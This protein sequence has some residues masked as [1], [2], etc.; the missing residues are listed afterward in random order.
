[1]SRWRSVRPYILTFLVVLSFGYLWFVLAQAESAAHPR[2]RDLQIDATNVRKMVFAP[3]GSYLVTIPSDGSK[4][5]FNDLPSGLRHRSLSLPSPT[6]NQTPETKEVLL[7]LPQRISDCAFSPNDRRLAITT[8]S[9]VAYVCHLP[10]GEN[11]F[12]VEPDVTTLVLPY[13]IDMK[14]TN[15]LYDMG[16]RNQSV[17]YSPDGKLL[18][19]GS[20]VRME[21][22]VGPDTE[23]ISNLCI[24]VYDAATLQYIRS[25]SAP[26]SRGDFEDM[27]ISPDGRYVAIC[28]GPQTLLWE[29][30]TGSLIHHYKEGG[31]RLRFSGDS[32][33]LILLD[34]KGQLTGLPIAA[35]RVEPYQISS[36]PLLQPDEWLDF[37]TIQG[38]IY[39][40]TR[41]FDNAYFR[42][43][44][45][46][47]ESARIFK[48]EHGYTNGTPRL[49]TWKNLRGVGYGAVNSIG[50]FAVS[51]DQQSMVYVTLPMDAAA[52]VVRLRRLDGGIL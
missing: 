43:W 1:M 37:T 6:G 33:S 44:T 18:L 48:M 27:A 22:T 28:N 50:T 41:R 46:P 35:E 9:P 13:R 30:S 23:I 5:W 12:Q 4:L 17:S 11:P 40:L 36:G 8:N 25:F 26:D 42:D 3:N 16:P 15:R 32:R 51:S 21:Q 31:K 19:I 47:T 14:G 52:P 49:W 34:R 7:R 20:T 45:P 38:R 29:L 2:F 39:A 24:W 10:D